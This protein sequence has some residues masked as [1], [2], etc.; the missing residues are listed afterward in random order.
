MAPAA[1]VAQDGLI[2]HQ[3]DEKP[4]VLRRFLC[5][6]IG[7]CQDREVGV[8]RLDTSGRCDGIGEFQRGNQEK[9][10]TLEM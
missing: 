4:L 7:E 8:G 2:G 9:R 1:C 6:N 5:P 3:R 10:K